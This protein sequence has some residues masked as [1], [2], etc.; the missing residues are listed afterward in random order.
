[1]APSRVL[2]ALAALCVVGSI[3]NVLAAV[4]KD[5]NTIVFATFGDW[6]RIAQVTASAIN[7]KYESTRSRRG[8]PP[9]EKYM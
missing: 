1:M 6:V 5:S 9:S 4:A 7:Y 8:G 2:A 3:S